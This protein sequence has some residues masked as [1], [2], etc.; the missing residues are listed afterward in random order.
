LAVQD[1]VQQMVDAG[2]GFL[3]DM[4]W[5]PARLPG[6]VLLAGR[7]D[8]GRFQPDLFDALQIAC[9]ATLVDANP[10]RL[11]EFL[12][13][14]AVAKAALALI[15]ARQDDIA[16]GPD[17]RPCWPAG[18]AGSISHAR[19]HMACLVGRADKGHPGIDIETIAGGQALAAI[20]KIALTGADQSIV[21][22]LPENA[23]ARVSR[24]IFSGKE[25][26]FKAL[27]PMVGRHFGFAAAELV[28]VPDACSFTLR[29]TQGLGPDLPQGAQFRLQW[30][31]TRLHVMTWLVAGQVPD[32]KTNSSGSDG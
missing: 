7:H 11:A 24:L 17:R 32:A 4:R 28:G 31:A 30:D 21:A 16:I 29:L 20:G 8:V 27:F 3:S 23:A 18:V 22:G 26:L 12:A 10:R 9:P 5:H 14:R 13:G 19:G 15:G 6:M 1:P 25:A 2:R